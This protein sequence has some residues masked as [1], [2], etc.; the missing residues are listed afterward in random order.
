MEQ[1]DLSLRLSISPWN[2]LL[3]RLM[4]IMKDW[5]RIGYISFWTMLI[6]LI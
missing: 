1:D 5:N 6:I 4:K 3:G 2:T